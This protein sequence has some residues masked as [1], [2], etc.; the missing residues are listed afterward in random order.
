MEATMP[1][2]IAAQRLAC[3]RTS[4]VLIDEIEELCHKKQV[5]RDHL[6]P[7]AD[8]SLKLSQDLDVVVKQLK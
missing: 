5:L 8:E 2:L 6:K 7:W 1:T 4:H 3:L